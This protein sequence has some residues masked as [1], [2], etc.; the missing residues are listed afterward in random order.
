MLGTGLPNDVVPY[1]WSDFIAERERPGSLAATV[2]A[3]G[4]L[5]YQDLDLRRAAA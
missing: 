1:A 5:L 4:R 3:E 2:L